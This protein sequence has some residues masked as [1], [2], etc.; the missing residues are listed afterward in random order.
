MVSLIHAIISDTVDTT[1]AIELTEKLYAMM[2]DILCQLRQTRYAVE[3]EAQ[4]SSLEQLILLVAMEEIL[5]RGI[6]IDMD[7]LRKKLEP[8]P[9]STAA[10]SFAVKPNM[11]TVDSFKQNFSRFPAIKGATGSSRSTAS[12][13]SLPHS[14]GSPARPVRRQT[15]AVLDLGQNDENTSSSSSRLSSPK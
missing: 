14:G 7:L 8:S 2:G 3:T 4:F 13:F 10:P 9:I 5:T 11:P 6:E 15:P 12:Y 1:Q